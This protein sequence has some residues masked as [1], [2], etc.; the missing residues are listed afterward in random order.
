MFSCGKLSYFIFSAVLRLLPH[1]IAPHG[2]GVDH[3]FWKAYIEEYRKN[4]VFPPVLSQFLLDVYQWY[5][6]LYPL[7]LSKLPKK[8]FD[9]YSYPK[10]FF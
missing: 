7:A 5:P 2:V 8:F 10:K 9:Q 4:G 6:P 1:F 3:W